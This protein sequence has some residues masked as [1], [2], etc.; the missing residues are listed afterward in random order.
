MKKF[1]YLLIA[2][3]IVTACDKDDDDDN[4]N[5]A[6]P[7]FE[8]KLVGT[9]AF[10]SGT[11]NTEV[12]MYNVMA[13]GDSVVFA[14]NSDA[15]QVVGGVLLGDSPCTDPANTGLEMRAD[16]SLFY[17]CIGESNETQMGTWSADATN[18]SISLN[19]PDPP[20]SIPIVDIVLDDTGMNGSITMLPLPIDMS[21]PIGPTNMQFANVAVVFVKLY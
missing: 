17:V 21:Q 8:E 4:N 3:L 7:T 14:P 1:M 2:V 15:T 18:N 6:P 5:P 13:P 12:T 11:F 10:A 9:Y 20:I 19:I 16:Y